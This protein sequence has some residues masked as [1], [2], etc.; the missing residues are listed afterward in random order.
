MLG[1]DYVNEL[2]ENGT[3]KLASN[4]H[5]CHL[6][7][8]TSGQ[9]WTQTHNPPIWERSFFFLPNPFH[10]TYQRSSVLSVFFLLFSQ[11]Y[12]SENA[13]TSINDALQIVGGM[14][15]MK[16][17]PYERYLRDA[18]ILQIFEVSFTNKR[19]L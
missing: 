14:G 3:Y 18:R 9:G 11:V 4:H 12:S 8:A 17:Y 1:S 15:Y 13:W 19:G 10:V 2:D 16:D 6:F 5:F 7:F